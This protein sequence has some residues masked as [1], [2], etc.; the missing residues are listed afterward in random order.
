MKKILYYDCFAGIS[1]DMNLGALVDL[2]VPAEYLESELGKLAI[3]G[4]RLDVTRDIRKGVGGTRVR[5]VVDHPENEKHRHLHHIEDLISKSTLSE[6]VKTKAMEIFKKVAVAEAKVHNIDI[7]KVHFHEV[8]ALDSIADIVGA[9]ICQEYLEVD[10]IQASAVQL[11][12][13]MVKCAHGLMPVPAPATAEIL[14]SIPV[15]SGLVEYEATTPTGAAILAATVDS[16][17]ELSDLN[18]TKIGYGI[19]QRDGEIPNVLRVYLAEGSG[20]ENKDVI[21][22]EAIMIECNLDDMSPESYTHVMEL[23]FEAGAADVFIIPTVMKKSRPGH[24]LHVL[25]NHKTLEPLKEIL[26]RET[27]SIGLREHTLKK[28]MLRRET[29]EVETK[30]GK[31]EVKRSFWNG[32]VVNEK[33]EFEQCR[34]LAL[35]HGVA[36]EEVQKEVIKKL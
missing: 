23:L 18:I 19:G 28:S 34:K 25:C 21:T 33:P 24:M 4:F 9:A 14:A 6:R 27:P 20:K 30:Y 35:D 2:G 5:V 32:R 22:E 36:L 16:F 26:F 1:G 13:G 15:R 12:G 8:G 29:L 3:E 31:V 10:E 17:C 11:G 7:Q